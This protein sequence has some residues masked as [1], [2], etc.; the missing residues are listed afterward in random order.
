MVVRLIRFVLTFEYDLG[1]RLRV[2]IRVGVRTEKK[3]RFQAAVARLHF[4]AQD[5]EEPDTFW[6]ER[7]KEPQFLR[8]MS[9]AERAKAE[10]EAASL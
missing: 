4:L 10:A 6:R 1:H 8:E 2:C 7:E 5:E 9:Y 3:M